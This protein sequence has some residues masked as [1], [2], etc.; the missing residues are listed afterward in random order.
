[1]EEY[2]KRENLHSKVMSWFEG[3][4]GTADIVHIGGSASAYNV[5]V[6][7][8]VRMPAE[9][10]FWKGPRPTIREIR[11]RFGKWMKEGDM[12]DCDW[13]VLSEKAT[14]DGVEMLI[15][16]S[17][18]WQDERAFLEGAGSAR[19]MRAFRPAAAGEASVRFSLSWSG[20]DGPAEG[21]DEYYIRDGLYDGTWQALPMAAAEGH[22][23]SSYLS[24]RCGAHWEA[25]II[26]D[27]DLV[28]RMSEGDMQA[29][30]RAFEEAA[31]KFNEKQRLGGGGAK[32]TYVSDVRVEYATGEYFGERRIPQAA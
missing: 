23:R 18:H 1:M 26:A 8:K 27:R 25:G 7:T 9:S 20:P 31:E 16:V 11:D 5:T 24:V 29:I 15:D 30:Q 22:A 10:E 12:A 17:A 6:R 21:S 2:E 32:A 28:D 19:G 4:G 14:G 13:A 3:R